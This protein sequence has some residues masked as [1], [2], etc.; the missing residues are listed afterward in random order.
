MQGQGIQLPLREGDWQRAVAELVVEGAAP[1]RYGVQPKDSNA[2]VSPTSC[3]NSSNVCAA[4]HALHLMRVMN[5]I[6]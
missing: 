3:L 4:M 6:R 2:Q 5:G 1:T